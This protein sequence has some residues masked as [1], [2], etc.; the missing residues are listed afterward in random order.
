SGIMEEYFYSDDESEVL[1]SPAPWEKYKEQI[2]ILRVAS[3]ITR[4][5]SEAF[6]ECSNLEQVYLSDSVT[7]IGEDAFYDCKKLKDIS[8]FDNLIR[9]EKN[10]FW[11]CSS[12]ESVYLPE[13]VQEIEDGVFAECE[14]LKQIEVDT[15]N[16]KYKSIDGSLYSKGGT[17][18]LRH[19]DAVEVTD[20]EGVKRIGVHAFSGCPSLKKVL[21]PKEVRDIEKFAFYHCENLERVYVPD[22]IKTIGERAFGKCEKAG[23]RLPKNWTDLTGFDVDIIFTNPGSKTEKE[24]K[25]WNFPVYEEALFDATELPLVEPEL[26]AK[27]TIKTTAWKGKRIVNHWYGPNLTYRRS[28]KKVVDAYGGTWG[29]GVADVEVSI[30]GSGHFAKKTVHAW[31]EV[32]PEA[33]KLQIKKQSPKNI[34]VSWEKQKQVM[35]YQL[36]YSTDKNW[37]RGVKTIKITDRGVTKKQLKQLKAKQTYYIRVRSYWTGKT[38]KKNWK[39]YGDWSKTKTVKM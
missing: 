26:S 2:R 38:E 12:L 10:A 31:V 7:S 1:S 22:G 20:L 35:G 32:R 19:C 4:I 33:Q 6:F 5:G 28:D 27:K 36:Q 13:S 17:V 18:L 37:K 3:G 14:Q 15:K 16:P 21:L 34:E 8:F 23:I 39:L 29:P 25:E 11:G 30:G 9:I 24:A